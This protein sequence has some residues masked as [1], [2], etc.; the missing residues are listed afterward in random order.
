MTLWPSPH[1]MDLPSG[2]QHVFGIGQMPDAWVQA[3]ALD[4]L[5]INKKPDH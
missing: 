3:T 4:S 1:G 5:R 2:L